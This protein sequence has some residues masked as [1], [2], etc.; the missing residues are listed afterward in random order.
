MPNYATITRE[1]ETVNDYVIHRVTFEDGVGLVTISDARTG[2]WQGMHT[3]D[4]DE[5]A[6]LAKCL[7]H[8][9]DA[10]SAL[11]VRRDPGFL[12]QRANEMSKSLI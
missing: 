3:R 11:R 7:K 4:E 10:C 6:S 12:I 8:L 9:I 2:D 1:T 5:N